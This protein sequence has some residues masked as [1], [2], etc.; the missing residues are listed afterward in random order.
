MTTNL[1]TVDPDQ[2]ADCALPHRDRINRLGIGC[3][4]D[5]AGLHDDHIRHHDWLAFTGDVDGSVL[6]S[7]VP[8]TGQRRN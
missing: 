8:A 2:D 5:V 3:V 1:R 4:R 7:D 6:H